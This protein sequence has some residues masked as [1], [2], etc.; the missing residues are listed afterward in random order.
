MK[1]ASAME[2][3]LFLENINLRSDTSCII[4]NGIPRLDLYISSLKKMSTSYHLRLACFPSMSQS[5]HS[6]NL[7]F[8]DDPLPVLEKLR[9]LRVL[10]S[11][12]EKANWKMCCS[13]GDFQQLHELMFYYLTNLEEWKIKAGA[14]PM[15]K[16]VKLAYC[17]NLGLSLGLQY[18]S[19]LKELK[20]FECREL[21]KHAGEIRSICKHVPSIY[22]EL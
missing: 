21:R 15:L 19:N 18:L 2:T 4:I 12:G 3:I 11:A 7:Q 22:I 6:K 9:S 10:Q 13:A 20:V 1:L 8:Q 5:L 14:I 16:I 17:E